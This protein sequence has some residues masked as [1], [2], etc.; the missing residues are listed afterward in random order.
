M[1]F[2]KT[3]KNILKQVLMLCLLASVSQDLYGE[4]VGYDGD[5]SYSQGAYQRAAKDLINNSIATLD[6]ASDTVAGAGHF[7]NQT[8]NFGVWRSSNN[9]YAVAGG[10]V[11]FMA[12][13]PVFAGSV[14]RTGGLPPSPWLAYKAGPFIIDSIYGGVGGMY[15]DYTGNPSSIMPGGQGYAINQNTQ[16]DNWAAVIWAQARLTAYVT[17]RLAISINPSVYYLPLTDQFGWGAGQFNAGLGQNVS[18][19]ALIQIGMRSPIANTFEAVFFDDFRA[20]Y[21]QQSLLRNSPQLWSQ[22]QDPTAMDFAGRYAFGG[23]GGEATQNSGGS[24]SLALRD[25]LFSD[26]NMSYQNSALFGLRGRH[27]NNVFSNIYFNKM[28]Y[29]DHNLDNH[30]DWQM[31][32]AMIFQQGPVISPYARFEMS[33]SSASKSWFQYEVIGASLNRDPTLRAFVEAGWLSSHAEAQGGDQEE[34]SYIAK[35]GINHVLGPYTIHG[36]EGGRS[37]VENYFSRYLAT[38]ARYYL[39]QQIGPYSSIQFFAQQADLESLGGVGTTA[40]RTNTTVGTSAQR[41]LTD[42]SSVSFTASFER[43]DIPSIRRS[44][45]LWTYR[46]MYNQELGKSITGIAYYQYQEAGS[47][48][49]AADSFTE[50]L[51]F[52]GLMKR[53]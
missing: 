1:K 15:S 11:G 20:L 34:S 17:D 27:S 16:Q 50:Q 30:S 49:T 42:K 4:A 22:Y 38:Y 37:P 19:T 33:E 29:F 31:F 5:Y 43:G 35:M 25:G 46:L 13:A 24:S 53:F 3:K 44:Y 51:L 12:R 10:G 6:Y 18:P 14:Q 2:Y 21:Q 9:A 39:T 40:D 36:F 8:M 45:D 7:L 41:R 47:C 32:G 23:F 48:L 28:D 52:V 26:K